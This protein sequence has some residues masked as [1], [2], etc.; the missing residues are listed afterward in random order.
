MIFNARIWYIWIDI[1]SPDLT[2][3]D[4]WLCDHLGPGKG[5]SNRGT[6]KYNEI[7]VCFVLFIRFKVTK[8]DH[9]LTYILET[10]HDYYI[11]MPDRTK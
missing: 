1:R 6:L 8:V 4:I 5:V 9:F 3:P 10:W 2:I 11:C 7:F